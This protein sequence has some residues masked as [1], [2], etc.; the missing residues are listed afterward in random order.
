MMVVEQG[1]GKLVTS[2]RPELDE[3]H[4][5]AGEGGVTSKQL[6]FLGRLRKFGTS[7]MI[8]RRAF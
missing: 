3:E 4:G 7:Q 1:R 5:A 2:V 8:G 6:H